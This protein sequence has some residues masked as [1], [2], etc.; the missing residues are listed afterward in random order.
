MERENFS[1][2]QTENAGNFLCARIKFFTS[3]CSAKIGLD[4]YFSDTIVQILQHTLVPSNDCQ[5][6][7]Q[8]IA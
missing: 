1:K 3:K 4:M 6:E 8:W 5:T 2:L 7:A